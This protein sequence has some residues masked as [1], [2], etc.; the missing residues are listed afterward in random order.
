MNGRARLAA[1]AA[2]LG[3][4]LT[5]K[6]EQPSLPVRVGHAPALADL[7]SPG[8]VSAA[9]KRA[10]LKG[11]NDT[12]EM[13]KEGRSKT[14]RSCGQYLAATDAGYQPADAST[15]GID[16]A[17]LFALRCPMLREIAK[18]HPSQQSDLQTF[19]FT[20]RSLE[21]LPA[22]VAEGC[23]ADAGGASKGATLAG[24]HV[25]EASEGHLDFAADDQEV[26]LDVAAWGDFDGDGRE[27]IL[28]QVQTRASDGEC[29]SYGQVILTRW[30][31]ERVLAVADPGS[32]NC[33][34]ARKLVPT[35]AK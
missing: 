8:G 31:G 7:K 18:A 15:F 26:L 27:D 32:T 6:A 21:E 10:P 5:A 14:V 2:L 25:V 33:S 24:A 1:L 19:R 30:P 17:G 34:V 9:L 16:Q 3:G 4:A 20:R 35:P 13:E 11:E 12:L 28:V 29:R 23:G 22:C